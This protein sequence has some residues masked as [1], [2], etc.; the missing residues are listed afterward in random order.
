MVNPIVLK[1]SAKHFLNL[2]STAAY[3][4]NSLFD[5]YMKSLVES[6]QISGS[7]VLKVLDWSF[8]N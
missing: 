7:S 4:K 3:M 2:S 6:G 1:A 8:L 5:F